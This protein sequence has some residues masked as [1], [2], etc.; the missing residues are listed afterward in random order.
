[1]LIDRIAAVVNGEVITFAQL[2]RALQMEETEMAGTADTCTPPTTPD[3]DPAARRLQCMIDG[4]LMF[5]HVRRFPQFDVRAEDIEAQ[6]ERLVE[7]S[8]SRQAFEDELQRLQLTPGEVRYDLE[9]QALIANYVNLRYRAVVDI[10]ESA[11]RRYYDEDLRAEMERQ[12]AE[13]PR[14]EDVDDE[15][16]RPILVETE[17]NRRVEEWI[18]ELRRRA[19]IILYLW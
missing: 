8:G 7:Q 17:V 9:R 1:M 13:L 4:L 19:D 15:F 12:A 10:P 16:I 2:N 6:Y 14:F 18:A 3:A 11:V 5:Q